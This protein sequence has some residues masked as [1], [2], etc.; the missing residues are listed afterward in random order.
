MFSTVGAVF[1]LLLVGY[2]AKRVGALKS[3]DVSVVNSLV[4]NLT[5][6]AFIF[7]AIQ[8]RPLTIQMVRGPFI[9]FIMTMLIIPVAYLVAKMMKLDKR[10]TGGFI[11]AAA[12]GNT[13]FL[14][15]PV[16]IAAF[17]GHGQAL[18]TAVMIDQFSMAL[19]L[20]SLGVVIAASCSSTRINWRHL[21]E[22]LKFPL[23]LSAIV[24][25]ALHNM[26]IP[27]VVIKS[28]QLLGMATV[29]LAM[30]SLG[31][32]I[33]RSSLKSATLPSVA[34][35]ILKMA[36]L[37]ILTYIGFRVVGAGGVIR[38]VSVLEASMPSA[39]MAGVIA[40]RYK[41]NESFVAAAT[42]LMTLTSLITIPIILHLLG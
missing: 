34:A 33:K 26:H 12:F 24:A 10:T 3:S 36:L 38:N 37:P 27:D 20:Y 11:L 25:I 1:L 29:P 23:F 22:F 40:G 14:G 19:P 28:I 35:L 8:N 41:A 4:V 16:T 32:S 15:Y 18:A 17:P 2:G 39:I 30:I 21:F 31:L 5:G 7:A 6:P 9:V 13:G 42:F